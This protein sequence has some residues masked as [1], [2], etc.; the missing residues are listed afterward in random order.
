MKAVESHT[1]A[2]T[3]SQLAE[4]VDEITQRLNRGEH[5]D[6]EEYARRFPAIAE[7]LVRVHETLRFI[8]QPDVELS[9]SEPPID[10][11]LGDFRL[12]REIGRGGMGVVYEAEQLSLGR[13]VALK[14]LPFAA[15]LDKQQLAR[16]KN[17]ARAAATLDH[18][19]IVAIYSVGTERGVHYYAMH[20]VE[21]QS[22]AQMLDQLRGESP[23]GNR[24][25]ATQ[26]H[27][28]DKDRGSEEDGQFTI[29]PPAAEIDTRPI[30]AQ[31]TIPDP[32]SREYCRTV[33]RLGVQAAE[34]LDHAHQ[35]GIIHRD[36]KPGNLMLD[37]DGKL[38]VTDF[39]LARIEQD[40]G[41]TMTGDIVGTLRYM[42]PEQA[43]AKRVVVDHR[44]DIYSLGVTLYELL[45]LQPPFTGEN[46]QE[47]LRQ[48]AFEDPRAPRRINPKVPADL[49][50]I[51][52]KAIRKDPA[53]RF[54]TAGD[55]AADLTRFLRNEPI[56]ARRPTLLDRT[57]MWSRRNRTLVAVGVVALL[58]FGGAASVTASIAWREQQRTAEALKENQ[59]IVDFFDGLLRQAAPNRVRSGPVTVLE[60]LADAERIIFKDF[61][62]GPHAKA[63]IHRTIGRAY[64]SLGKY[65]LAERHLTLARDMFQELLGADHRESLSTTSDLAATFSEQGRTK[66]AKSL[67]D[68]VVRTSRRAFGPDD[69][70]T[71]QALQ[72]VAQCLNKLGRFD[73]AVTLGRQVLETRRSLL[74]EEHRE[75]LVSM[76]HLAAFLDDQGK[77]D[78]ARLLFEQ[79]FEIERRVLGPD[80][81]DTLFTSL[82]RA[83]VVQHQGKTDE[84]I[85]GFEQAIERLQSIVG[86]EHFRTLWAKGILA[87]LYFEQGQF[88]PA[89]TLN[90]DVIEV[91][92][93]ALGPEH[94]Q[95]LSSMSKQA[96][97]L[98]FRKR[99]LQEAQKL[100]AF[101]ID[102]QRRTLGSSHK[103]TLYSL[104]TL[105]RLL[106]DQG[107][108]NEAQS[109]FEEVIQ[110][111]RESLG[112]NHPNTL[113]SVNPLA[114]VLKRRGANEEACELFESIL[115]AQREV[116]GSEHPST[117][118]T[119]HNLAEA[120]RTLGQLDEALS[121]HQ[122]VLEIRRRVLPANH[123]YT[124]YSMECLARLMRDKGKYD[125]ARPIFEQALEDAQRTLGPENPQT[126]SSRIE[127]AHLLRDE[128]KLDE[129]RAMLDQIVEIAQRTLKPDDPQRLE[130]TA[131]LAR[132]LVA[133]G[134]FEDALSLA[135]ETL[136]SQERVLNQDRRDLLFT[137]DALA[138]ALEGVG[139]WA[140]ARQ[141]REHVVEQSVSNL[142]ARHPDRAEMLRGLALHLATAEDATAE[143]RKRAIELAKEATVIA[144]EVPISS[145]TLGV[146]Y[147]VNARWQESLDAFQQAM[148]LHYRGELLPQR[149]LMQ[150]QRSEN[151]ADESYERLMEMLRTHARQTPP[152]P[153]RQPADSTTSH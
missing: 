82:N 69:P 133:Q 84:A 75:V 118:N 1:N 137:Q 152:A 50:T 43:L 93:E 29:R 71:L 96:A 72:N 90:E 68:E 135:E 112:P 44:T 32:G 37:A 55:F 122:Q 59:I 53:D 78:E 115:P 103:N 54:A 132:L 109:V 33:A 149:V 142:G 9:D 23:A 127:L 97:M 119:M 31:G 36:V 89:L 11:E 106:D 124:F 134:Q 58:L 12:L 26:N 56:R 8:R 151:M 5:V 3:D 92:R 95:T 140:E 129:A 38:W 57:R 7:Q 42:S 17:E 16:F 2:S 80:H 13:H 81:L 121:M 98:I 153:G 99:D 91:Q 20:L 101:V 79:A 108:L 70:Q 74:G 143:D 48:I 145:R 6:M 87:G 147:A 62:G 34:A 60:A 144:P 138:G 41:M 22:L 114:N 64:R 40:A 146:V 21:G 123:P 65:D 105:G 4:V 150:L 104:K 35:N 102:A 27:G 113:E 128:G 130:I 46:R 117:L 83:N 120:L 25:D 85:V 139:R 14:V 18:P 47:L 24:L 111:S 131:N 51:I 30:A 77:F 116:L 136:H 125:Q 76:N 126:L 28:G 63:S 45:T 107:K 86:G 148:D 39:G 10:R 141:I 19:N 88:E 52:L 100:L 61:K 49:E 15:M 66:E 110:L 94:P 73:E 67:Y